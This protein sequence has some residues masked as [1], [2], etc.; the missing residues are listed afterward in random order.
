M[1]ELIKKLIDAGKQDALN[2]LDELKK[3]AK[4][5]GFSEEQ[6]KEALEGFSGFPLDDD[7][8]EEITGGSSVKIPSISVNRTGY[9]GGK[10]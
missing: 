4:E 10:L 9:D 1:K 6:V 2:S 3:A 7:D 5:L 8:L